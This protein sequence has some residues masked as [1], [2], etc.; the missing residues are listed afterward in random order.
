[1]NAD[2]VRELLPWYAAGALSPAERRAV[3]DQLRDSPTLRNELEEYRRLKG[4]VAETA[5]E[6]PE[7][8]P[9]M[10]ERTWRSIDEYEQTKQR[11]AA[12][13]APEGF[14]ARW[15]K[16]WQGLPG[17]GRLALAT[18]FAVI[19]VLGGVLIGIASREQVFTTASGPDV[20]GATA[21]P[22]FTVVFQPA[23][24][25]TAIRDLLASVQLQIVAGPSAE[26][27][28]VLAAADGAQVE[29]SAALERLRGAAGVVRFAA[30]VGE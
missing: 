29:A 12:A 25:E 3:E 7:F 13:Q 26:G 4:V 21:G 8:R 23:A 15:R 22:R 2:E 11:R 1:M 20:T 6:E 16:G 24:T 5:A 30:P 27:G 17:G 9:E 10:I 19:L 18:Q 28:Y 14:L